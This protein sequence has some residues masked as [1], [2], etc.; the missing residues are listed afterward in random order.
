[1]MRNKESLQKIEREIEVQ[2]RRLEELEGNEGGE[3]GG[4]K[5]E[6]GY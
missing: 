4:D 1:V 5:G 3:K 6:G 2:R